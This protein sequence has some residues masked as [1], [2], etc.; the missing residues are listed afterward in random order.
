MDHGEHDPLWAK[1][2]GLLRPSGAVL[3]QP[4]DR[5]GARGSERVNAGERVGDAAG[6]VLHV[7]DD[8]VVAGEAG[9]LGQCGREAEEKEAVEGL[10]IVE[11]GFEGFWAGDCGDI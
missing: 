1:I 10:A 4:E 9:D 3:G 8:V 2:Q 5:G 6:A 7:D 11:T